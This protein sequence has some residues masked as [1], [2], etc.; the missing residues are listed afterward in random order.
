M[1][2]DIEIMIEYRLARE[3]DLHEVARIHKDQFPT[4]Y[5][6]QFST[7]LLET[8]YRNLLDAGYVFVVAVKEE[9]VIGF[10]LGGEWKK[11]SRSLSLFMK[12]NFIR[13]LGESVIRP[14]TWK[15][16]ILKV[17][18]L[19]GNKVSDPNN[20]DNL[21]KFT[22]LSI[23]TSKQSQGKGIGR[24]LISAFD[25]EMKKIANRY[26]LSVQDTNFNAIKFYKKNGFVEAYSCVGEIQMIKTL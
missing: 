14:K 13:S 18:S 21:E 8:F 11:I 7:S 25:T 26:Y 15:K 1:D 20:L 3:S 24:G 22:L 10:V 12:H 4:H 5:L 17:V 9:T 2:K 16:S 6:G 23:A 19:F